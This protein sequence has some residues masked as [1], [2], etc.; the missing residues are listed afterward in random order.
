MVLQQASHHGHKEANG[1]DRII[2]PASFRS[3]I[4]QRSRSQLSNLIPESSVAIVGE[5]GPRAY[6]VSQADKSEVCVTQL[7]QVRAHE[8]YKVYYHHCYNL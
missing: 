4:R 2:F 1:S 3:S 5:L 7:G 8:P 6:A